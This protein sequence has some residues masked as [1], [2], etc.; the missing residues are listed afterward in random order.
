[1]NT[2]IIVDDEHTARSRLKMLLKKHE[3]VIEVIGEAKDGPEAIEKINTES[4]GGLFDFK[5]L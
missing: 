1:M 4:Q 3:T 2:A 5:P